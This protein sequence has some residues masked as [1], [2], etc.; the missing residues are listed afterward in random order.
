[1]GS[2]WL[3]VITSVYSF[4]EELLKTTMGTQ[5]VW[6]FLLIHKELSNICVFNKSSFNLKVYDASDTALIQTNV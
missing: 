3:K 2:Q 4:S 6:P 1:M 5:D